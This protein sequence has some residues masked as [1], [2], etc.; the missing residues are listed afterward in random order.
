[1]PKFISFRLAGRT[2]SRVLRWALPWRVLQSFRASSWQI[3][4]CHIIHI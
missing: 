1:M 3:L 4:A 2:R